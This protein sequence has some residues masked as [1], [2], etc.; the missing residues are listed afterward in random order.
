MFPCLFVAEL[1]QFHSVW[2]FFHF[3]DHYGSTTTTTTTTSNL[4]IHPLPSRQSGLCVITFTR[5]PVDDWAAKIV[6]DDRRRQLSANSAR[7]SA[8]MLANRCCVGEWANVSAFGE[9][10]S[11]PCLAKFRL[12]LALIGVSF[13]DPREVPC[14]FRMTN[15]TGRN[16]PAWCYLDKRQCLHFYSSFKYL[17]V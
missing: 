3:N 7:K 12:P 10:T 2:W 1:R 9:S 14:K 16:H 6:I 15:H 13:N 5:L 11:Q 4:N 8:D 17:S